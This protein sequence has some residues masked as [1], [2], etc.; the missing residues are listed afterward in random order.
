MAFSFGAMV[1]A[2]AGTSSPRSR[3]ASFP[4]NFESPMLILIYACLVLGGVGSIGGAVLGGVARDGRCSRCSPSPTD[5]GYLFY[6]LIL[7]ALLVTRA[8]VAVPR[9]RRWPA[10]V[11]F[12][13]AV[14]AI[15]GAISHSAVDGST[16]Q[17]RLDRLGAAPL[18][19]RAGRLAP[20]TATSSSS[21]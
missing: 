20:P 3:A 10:I 15:V 8:P 13:F 18:R 7:L 1:A 6:G 4:T 9:A 11:G 19:D 16:G 12:G 14:R 2:L 17:R 21:C 5:A